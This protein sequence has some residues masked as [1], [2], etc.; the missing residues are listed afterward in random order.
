[1]RIWFRQY[2]IKL[3]KLFE[4]DFQEH[5]KEAMELLMQIDNSMHARRI[6]S[7]SNIKKSRFSGTQT[8][9]IVLF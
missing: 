1:M 6:E 4:A 8:E 5:E 9:R 3:S 2:L 7:E